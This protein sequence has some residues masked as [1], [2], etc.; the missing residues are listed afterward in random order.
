MKWIINVIKVTLSK[1]NSSVIMYILH[2]YSRRIYFLQGWPKEHLESNPTKMIFLYYRYDNWLLYVW[3][4]HY[5][6]VGILGR[7]WKFHQ[8]HCKII[9]YLPFPLFKKNISRPP[10]PTMPYCAWYPQVS[11][12]IIFY[13]AYIY[14]TKMY[15]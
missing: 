4:T 11:Y 14:M 2:V 7:Q 6:T 15:G 9:C 13:V 10:Y 3:E 1:L 8:D 5:W 12:Y